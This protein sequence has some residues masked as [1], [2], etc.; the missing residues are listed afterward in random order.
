MRLNEIYLSKTLL[1][2]GSAA[3][4]SNS[5]KEIKIPKSVKTIGNNAFDVF[6]LEKVYCG[7][8]EKPDGWHRDWISYNYNNT[9]VWGADI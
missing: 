3:F 2:I 8:N 1:E 4:M 7:A 5:L 9:V 6:S